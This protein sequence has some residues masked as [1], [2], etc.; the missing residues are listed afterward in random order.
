MLKHVDS[1]FNSMQ[2]L[3]GGYELKYNKFYIGMVKDGVSKN[4]L[5]FRPKKSF[6]KLG[7]KGNED[8]SIIQKVEDAGLEISYNARFKE[9]SLRIDNYN[10]Y[11]ANKSLID[12]LVKSSMEYFNLTD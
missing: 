2:D 11:L 4:F 5:T 6:I 1:I 9:Y 7:F 8:I 10:V 12:S 3:V